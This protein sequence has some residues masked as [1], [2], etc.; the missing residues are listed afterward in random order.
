MAQNS[1][2]T[3]IRN[4][5][6]AVEAARGEQALA[7]STLEYDAKRRHY[8]VQL[9]GDEKPRSITRSAVE[10][11][12]S[13]LLAEADAANLNPVD[14]LYQGL[15]DE[16]TGFLKVGQA[17]YLFARTADADSGQLARAVKEKHGVDFD[18]NDPSNS[19]RRRIWEAW[20][21]RAGIS[22][23]A[24]ARAAWTKLYRLAD[25]VDPKS[26]AE[27]QHD[28]TAVLEDVLRL[29]MNALEVK[30][31]GAPSPKEIALG[32][33]D[34][35]DDDAPRAIKLPGAVAVLGDRVARAVQALLRQSGDTK[36][37][38]S[39]TIYYERVN[40]LMEVLVAEQP[41]LVVRVWHQLEGEELDEENAKGLPLPHFSSV[42]R[43]LCEAEGV[44]MPDDDAWLS[45]AA[46]HWTP[47]Q[48]VEALKSSE[49]G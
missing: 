17:L 3:T 34:E 20:A 27:P 14:L 32:V 35:G 21:V 15:H 30:Y 5:R 49:A 37:T 22:A 45:R 47:R 42:L 8:K 39:R 26:G 40:A 24:L 43:N 6:A 25:I 36:A 13:E 7:D 28:A 48:T 38:V 44:L 33:E 11:L 2:E 10:A 23:D 18:Y 4:L 29:P 1:I 16:R 46:K 19:K 41:E 9:P 31:L 12:T